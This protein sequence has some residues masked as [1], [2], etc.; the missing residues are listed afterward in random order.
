VVYAAQEGSGTQ[1]TW[2][3]FLGFDPSAAT[4]AVN[5]Y[6]PS[7]GS[8]TCVGPAVILENEDAQITTSAFVTSQKKFVQ[9]FN[10]AWGGGNATTAKIRSDA[11]FFYSAGKFSEQCKVSAHDCGGSR[12][13]SGTTNAV[14]QINGVA[15]TEQTILDGQ[16]PD[17][18]YLYNV[19]SNGSNANIPAATAA[20]VNYVSELGFIC[21]PN[22]GS[23]TLTLDPNTGSTYVSEIQAVIEGA[24]FYPLS[25]GA[26]SGTVNQTPIDEGTLLNPASALLIKAGGQ[27]QGQTSADNG[28]AQYK[29]F[30][31]FATTGPNSD[32]AGYC[33]DTSTDSN[34]SS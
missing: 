26:G 18:R 12:L 13:P 20:T 7:G 19:Y 27:G 15:P 34:S 23:A 28:Y 5:C 9:H 25:A 14:E 1:S 22:K 30:D 29:P 33:L 11:I 6:T 31:T 17:D 32:P 16:F 24:G 4:N 3:T 21:N 10:P 8:N 2:K